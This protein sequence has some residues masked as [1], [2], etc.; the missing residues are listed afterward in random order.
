MNP[1]TSAASSTTPSPVTPI[2]GPAAAAGQP[3]PAT[4]D[5]QPRVVGGA[6]ASL[7][8]QTQ[9]AP[10]TVGAD[11]PVA[12]QPQTSPTAANRTGPGILSGNL[13]V[14][15]TP[16]T[17]ST[18]AGRSS[19]SSLSRAS[20][21][22]RN[23]N[24]LLGRSSAK[25]FT[26][27]VGS[28][29]PGDRRQTAFVTGRSSKTEL[30]VPRHDAQ[31]E[32]LSPE[33]RR[34]ARFLTLK[35]ICD[36]DNAV[37]DLDFV[38]SDPEGHAILSKALAD[39]FTPEN[40]DFMVQLDLALTAD[41]ANKTDAF[42]ALIARFIVEGAPDQLNLFSELR[43]RV[44]AAAEKHGAASEQVLSALAEVKTTVDTLTRTNVLAKVREEAG[45]RLAEMER[46][47][48]I[49]RKAKEDQA[50]APSSRRTA[51]FGGVRRSAAS[52]KDADGKGQSADR[53]VSPSRPSS[54][55]PRQSGT[56]PSTPR[57][58]DDFADR[59]S[60][61]RPSTPQPS[62]VSPSGSSSGS[63]SVA[64]PR[65]DASPSGVGGASPAATEGSAAVIAISSSGAV[66][67]VPKTRTDFMIACQDFLDTQDI[68]EQGRILITQIAP[69]LREPRQPFWIEDS[70][71]I[72]L[73][74]QAWRL[75]QN[76]PIGIAQKDLIAAVTHAQFL[77][78]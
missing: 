66:S 50:A 32:A 37:P 9:A 47:A 24:T 78:L 54:P 18:D 46:Q 52:K 20:D 11:Q 75:E 44:T 43:Q 72:L 65:S 67:R 3:L 70:N 49:D 25:G 55:T 68:A 21:G 4:N 12:P 61:T 5:Q 71:K 8:S 27:F 59:Q 2:S 36:L 58:S 22:A 62:D 40:D 23:S 42:A 7:V 63:S 60:G 26:A 77:A 73:L 35:V 30:T 34:A 69:A 45:R 74:E 14:S 56:R 51:L 15:P 41:P 76:L 31:L 53:A 38:R 16:G 1:T 19:G 28:R 57:P 64:A 39:Q 17:Q 6:S 10:A 48:E 33:Q 13:P 29:Q